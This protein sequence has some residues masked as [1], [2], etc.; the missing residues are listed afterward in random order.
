LRECAHLGIFDANTPIFSHPFAQR[1]GSSLAQFHILCFNL[2][3]G[4]HIR[5]HCW[6]SLALWLR[7]EP[8]LD[9]GEGCKHDRE[10]LLPSLW[11]VPV[12]IQGRFQTGPTH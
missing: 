12:A 7:L 4:L 3:G 6:I 5:L 10:G 2:L 1:G 9:C 8:A 11:V